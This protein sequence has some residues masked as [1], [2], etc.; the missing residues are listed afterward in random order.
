MPVARTARR[1]VDLFAPELFT[2]SA[3]RLVEV[4]ARDLRK[5]RKDV[6]EDSINEIRVLLDELVQ[7]GVWACHGF[8]SLG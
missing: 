2:H 4:G 5:L 7:L 8:T 1:N 6:L 3:L